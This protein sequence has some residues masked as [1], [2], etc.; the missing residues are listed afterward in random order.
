MNLP[1]GNVLKQGLIL[2]ENDAKKLVAGLIE[3][4]F[5]GYVAL[6]I[7]GFDGLEEGTLLFKRG[8]GVACIFEYLKFD[9]TVISDLAL[10]HFFN[11]AGASFGIIDAV[12]LSDLQVDMSIAFDEKI[13]LST[14]LDKKALDKFS[15]SKFDNSF[16]EKTLQEAISL[17]GQ[18]E[19]S[20][21]ELF[22]RFG[23]GEMQ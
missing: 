3:E 21:K 9:L 2:K 23:L 5:S 16:A 6:T 13:K 11:A 10:A 22:K 4:K 1:S 19:T 8:F 7:E 17:K 18:K 15:I 12:Q 20:K 14:A